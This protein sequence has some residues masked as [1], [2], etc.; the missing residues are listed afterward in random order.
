[1]FEG[2]SILFRKV[3]IANPRLGLHYTLWPHWH[4]ICSVN[5]IPCVLVLTSGGLA[6]P[7]AGIPVWSLTLLGAHRIAPPWYWSRVHTRCCVWLKR[8]LF[9]VLGSLCWSP[10]KHQRFFFIAIFLLLLSNPTSTP[11]L[12]NTHI[13][14][15]KPFQSYLKVL[16]DFTLF[17][18]GSLWILHNCAQLCSDSHLPDAPPP[19]ALL[20]F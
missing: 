7:P 1:M 15:S 20:P 11:C 5:Q 13:K 17:F 4:L 3:Q 19:C 8:S 18:Y 2:G 14:M 9:C 10:V 16:Q 12:Q 6:G